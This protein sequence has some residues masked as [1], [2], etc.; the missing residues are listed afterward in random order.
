MIRAGLRKSDSLAEN[1]C[2]L[3]VKP[4]PAFIMP[5]ILALF[6]TPLLAVFTE[7]LKASPVLL[8]SQNSV[9]EVWLT[10]QVAFIAAPTTTSRFFKS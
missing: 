8:S 1:L 7:S 5:P 3:T 10:K 2:F 9:F 6:K 4:S